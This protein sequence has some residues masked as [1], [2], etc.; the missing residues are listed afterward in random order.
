M[1][2][3]KTR[4]KEAATAT[5]SGAVTQIIEPPPNVFSETVGATGWWLIGMFGFNAPIRR[6][7]PMASSPLEHVGE[8][9]GMTYDA[10][11]ALAWVKEGKKP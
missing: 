3:A 11:A 8:I 4:A 5:A 6:A 7:L 1:A 2:K 10:A 9:V